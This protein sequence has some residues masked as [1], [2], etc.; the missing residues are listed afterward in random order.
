MSEP[1]YFDQLSQG[2][3]WQ[4]RG[5]TITEADVTSFAG[6][7]GDYDPL[8]VDHHFASQTPFGRPVAHGLLGLSYMAGM[9]STCP[10]VHT[11]A[12]LSIRQWDFKKPIFIGDTVRVVTQVSR[13]EST[14]R[15]H[16]RVTWHRQLVNQNDEVVQEGFL[17]TLVAVSPN[18]KSQHQPLDLHQPQTDVVPSSVSQP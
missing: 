6:L 9:S 8:H 18:K 16:G 15:R 3:R 1:L 2:D 4:T 12:F 17:E 10:A 14:S 13:V 7:T 5:R 11:N